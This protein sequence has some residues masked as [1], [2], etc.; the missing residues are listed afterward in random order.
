MFDWNDQELAKILWGEANDSD[1]HIVPY[2][3]GSEVRLDVSGDLI[4]KG[5]NEDIA[6]EKPY[7]KES[8][9]LNELNRVEEEKKSACDENEGLSAAGHS[10]DSGNALSLSTMSKSCQDSMDE[11]AKL[12]NGTQIF[13]DHNDDKDSDLIGYGWDNIGSFEDL[14]RIFR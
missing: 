11:P 2:P 4:K 12:Y 7:K 6:N 3:S 10:V 14:D 13:Q 5:W 8:V 9:P 1:D